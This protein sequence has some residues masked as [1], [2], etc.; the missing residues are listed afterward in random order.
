MKQYSAGT[1]VIPRLVYHVEEW[2]MLRV[3]R[4][5]CRDGF[6]HTTTEITREQQDAYR[7]ACSTNPHIRHYLYYYDGICVGFSRLE[8]RDG[9]VYPTYGVAPWARGRGFAWDI[10]KLALLAAGGPL[11]GD[12]LMTNEAIKKVDYALGFVKVDV[13]DENGVQQVQCAWPPPFVVM[14]VD[15]EA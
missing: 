12:L 5:G 1:R 15:K 6:T 8:W 9:F 10:V 2:E 11:K 3:I 13:P 4:N 7:Q 14:V